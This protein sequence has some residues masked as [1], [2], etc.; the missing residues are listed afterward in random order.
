V[1]RQRN[2]G[3]QHV[4]GHH[5][6]LTDTPN[7]ETT[8]AVPMCACSTGRWILTARKRI[9]KCK[10]PQ[11]R[12]SLSVPFESHSGASFWRAHLLFRLAFPSP[13]AVRERFFFPR[14]GPAASTT[15]KP[16]E[17]KVAS[18]G[19]LV[20]ALTKSLRTGS[21]V[22]DQGQGGCPWFSSDFS[23]HNSLA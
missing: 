23:I 22:H 17:R 9:T 20:Y 19:H 12:N 6:I 13:G 21:T 7:L 8:A 2:V 4:R 15:D 5:N 10:G 1:L 18:H 16:S 14:T 11:K 3:G